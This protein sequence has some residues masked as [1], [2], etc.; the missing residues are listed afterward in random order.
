MMLPSSVI[1]RHHAEGTPLPKWRDRVPTKG[2]TRPSTNRKTAQSCDDWWDMAGSTAP[3]RRAWWPSSTRR[4][5]LRELPLDNY[6]CRWARVCSSR[7][8]LSFC[9]YRRAIPARR[10]SQA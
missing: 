5:G 9:A 4:H 3:R 7:R 10:R 8:R 6:P 2:T 1:L